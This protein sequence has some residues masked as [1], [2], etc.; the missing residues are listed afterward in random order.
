VEKFIDTPV[1]FYSSGMKVRLGFS[2]AAHLNPEI[3]IIDEVL[4]VGDYEFQ[5]KC[6]G[7]MEEVANQGRTVLFVSH[8]LEAVS[9]LCSRAILLS[10]GH[11]FTSG[12]VKPVID[13][14]LG[15]GNNSQS[16]S[17]KD[18]KSLEGS[19]IKEIQIKTSE[20]N[21]HHNFGKPLEIEFCLS[22]HKKIP[23]ATLSFQL[24]DEK[25]RAILH[26]WIFQS[27][28]KF[29]DQ[30]GEYILNCKIDSPKLYMGKYYLTAHFGE[31]KGGVKYQQIENAC[32][33]EINMHGIYREFEWSPFASAYLENFKWNVEAIN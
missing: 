20:R 31:G 30:P 28:N 10:N 7:K 25:N 24:F 12:L 18:N 16:N 5:K 8:N 29:C 27:E 9:N 14:Y 13:S 32:S 11:L 6:L 1:K 22:S 21:G 15:L 4:A 17:Y 3:L 2:V 33:F 23:N 19:F 26:A